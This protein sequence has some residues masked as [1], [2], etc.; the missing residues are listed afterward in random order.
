ML[1]LTSVQ[2]ARAAR[3]DFTVAGDQPMTHL[4]QIQALRERA[5][6]HIAEGAITPDYQLDRE[7]SIRILNEALAT[8][9][10]CTLRYQFHY[11]MATGIHS[12]AVKQEFKEHA[13]EEQEHAE[14]IA[15][16]IKQLGG[17]PVMNPAM[18]TDLS[19][20]EYR[21][22][23]TLAEMIREDLIA[24]RIAVE[25]YREMIR[26]FGDRDPT[27]R[28]MMEEILAKEE[29]HADEL[30]D[31]LFAVEPS[32]GKGARPLYFADEVGGAR[33]A[34]ETRTEESSH[35]ETS[36]GTRPKKPS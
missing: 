25:S 10:V 22:G 20:S 27:T 6:Q 18:L 7:Q 34:G 31:L 3:G 19:H 9:L 14:R 16:R 26:Y 5:R 35:R 15:E 12:Q 28:I 13:R 29:E 36:G 1:L 8:E 11:F 21:E 32:T 24:E 30:T 17:K 23:N 2:P 33:S 4:Q